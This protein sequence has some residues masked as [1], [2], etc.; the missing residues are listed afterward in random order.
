MTQSLAVVLPAV[1]KNSVS[2]RSGAMP[3]QGM[4]LQE[5]IDL[6]LL[7]EVGYREDEQIIWLP[8]GH[9]LLPNV[10]CVHCGVSMF[11]GPKLGKDLCQTCHAAWHDQGQPALGSWTFRPARGRGI[12]SGADMRDCRICCVPGHR[13]PTHG[14]DHTL[15]HT[16]MTALARGRG[17]DGPLPTVG[18]CGV[19]ACERL[20]ARTRH[21]TPLCEWHHGRFANAFAAG[22]QLEE[23]CRTQPS[24]EEHR[25]WRRPHIDLRGI[26]DLV[27][28]QLLAM[29]T[30]ALK[31]ELNSAARTTFRIANLARRYDIRDG[32][33]VSDWEELGS[34]GPDA[35]GRER[36]PVTTWRSEAGAIRHLIKLLRRA[37]TSVEEERQQDV[38]DLAVFGYQ[39]SG[40]LYFNGGPGRAGHAGTPAIRQQWLKEVAKEAVWGHI[41]AGKS[42]ATLHHLIRSCAEFGISL[43]QNRS[44]GGHDPASL[45]RSDMQ[46]HLMRLQAL[47]KVGHLSNG[48]HVH[49]TTYL[50]MIWDTAADN[51]D[52]WRGPGGP[53]EHLDPTCRFLATDVVRKEY[54]EPEDERAG[55]S[56][57]E[58]VMAQLLSPASLDVLRDVG[59]S[60]DVVAAVLIHANTGRRTSELMALRYECL[61]AVE[62]T[63]ADGTKRL[64]YDLIYDEPKKK[65]VHRYLPIHAATAQLIKDQQRRVLARFPQTPTKE[66]ALFPQV[67]QNRKG[68]KSAGTGSIHY[69]WSRWVT[70]LPTLDGPDLDLE[71]RPLPF[72]RD[73]VDPYAFRHTYA[74][75]HADAGVAPDVL[76]KLMGHAQL[77]TTQG[78][79]QV[80]R[81]RMRDAI[82][83]LSPLQLN[84]R[85]DR[86]SVEILDILDSD[87]DWQNLGGTSVSYG[88]CFEPTNVMAA[89]H[90]CPFSHQCLGCFHF[91][92][93]PSHL[94][95]LRHFLERR[96]VDQETLLT[97]IEAGLVT[98]WAADKALPDPHELDALR[99]LIER[100]EQE[101]SRLDVSTRARLQAT[102]DSMEAARNTIAETLPTESR[103]RV[104]NATVVHI[105]LPQQA[106]GEQA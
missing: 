97:A 36:S 70:A 17:L 87:V 15:C 72:D 9:H 89:G 95:D 11:L 24:I 105:D 90:A 39:R 50:R 7:V 59:A 96:L 16:H 20:A 63:A 34:A 32:F 47:A 6:P 76:R 48:Q 69:Y 40:F 77:N 21:E 106:V 81:Q 8:I 45:R 33:D 104:R 28:L 85:G 14:P 13:R 98:S 44:E 83:L 78:Y 56:L 19:N 67:Q 75:R 37:T 100:C 94:P 25:S 86:A 71:G 27:R 30:L 41:C 46:A 51:E 1:R 43:A 74:Q 23:F 42:I 82:D 92:T 68:K 12:D 91:R 101:L 93:D 64:R 4:A 66:L 31:S 38:W 10:G 79:Y 61:R 58:K 54:Q 84:S 73:L 99:H 80:S 26:E 57:P 102:F 18:T 49:W 103:H 29:L 2:V 60:E 35:H 52:V 22:Q 55:Q 62:T 65:V 88:S 5:I 53:F 3:T